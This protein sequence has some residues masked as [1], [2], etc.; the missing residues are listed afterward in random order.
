MEYTQGK[1]FR[2]NRL[3]A[4]VLW[5]DVAPVRSCEGNWRLPGFERLASV[6]SVDGH[7]DMSGVHVSSSRDSVLILTYLFLLIIFCHLELEFLGS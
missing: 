3:P 2:L 6:S 1:E 7:P 4:R 5:D